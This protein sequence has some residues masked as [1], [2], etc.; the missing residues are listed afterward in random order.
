MPRARNSSF[1]IS[2]KVTVA[3]GSTSSNMRW[4]RACVCGMVGDSCDRDGALVATAHPGYERCCPD[5][6]TRVEV[7]TGL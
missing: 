2:E 4:T 1:G 5:P 7:N 6:T 3:I